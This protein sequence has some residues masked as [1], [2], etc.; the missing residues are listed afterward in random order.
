MYENGTGNLSN[1]LRL[2]EIFIRSCYSC[3]IL[4]HH[5]L[6]KQQG[7]KGFKLKRLK[8]LSRDS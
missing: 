2:N 4:Y 8:G 6:T 5:E 1:N 3:L 7:F